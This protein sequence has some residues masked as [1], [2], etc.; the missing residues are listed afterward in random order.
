MQVEPQAV[1]PERPSA[2]LESVGGPA[3]SGSEPDGSRLPRPVIVHAAPA[4][5]RAAQCGGPEPHT[6]P[7]LRDALRAPMTDRHDE[8]S[9]QYEEAGE[10]QGPRVA[11]A[12]EIHF[13]VSVAVSFTCVR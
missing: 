3:A 13:A 6:A 8:Q 7:S 12:S 2:D 9:G 10:E 5:S 11:H 4:G 1:T